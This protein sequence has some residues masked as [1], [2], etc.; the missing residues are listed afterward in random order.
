MVSELTKKC[1]NDTIH[2]CGQCSVSENEIRRIIEEVKSACIDAVNETTILPSRDPARIDG[3]M[4][5]I[6][7][8]IRA[9]R[10]VE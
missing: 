5:G 6:N 3:F 4:L 7:K 8:A 9:I 10:E 1:Q 2:G